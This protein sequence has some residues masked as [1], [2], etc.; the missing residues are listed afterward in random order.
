MFQK[1]Q[2]ALLLKRINDRPLKKVIY[3]LLVAAATMLAFAAYSHLVEAGA[4]E[5]APPIDAIAQPTPNIPHRR[6]LKT[7]EESPTLLPDRPTGRPVIDS[8]DVGGIDSGFVPNVA[9]GTSRVFST[10]TQ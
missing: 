6:R 2:A 4:V 9:E 8:P 5:K 3:T 7:I 1:Y 10:A